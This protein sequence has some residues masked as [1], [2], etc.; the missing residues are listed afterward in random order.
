LT[1]HE[2][3]SLEDEQLQD[4]DVVL[5]GNTYRR[6][7]FTRCRLIFQGG[8]VPLLNDCRFVETEW[9]FGGAA[10][11]TVGFLNMLYLGGAKQIA[12]S[13]IKQIRAKPKQPRAPRKRAASKKTD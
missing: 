11:R 10:M 8:A 2:Q 12:E 5:D 9:A 7:T 1:S 4:Q 6:C 13:T 3:Q